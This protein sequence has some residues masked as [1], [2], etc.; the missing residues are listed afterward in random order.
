MKKNDFISAKS[1][2]K[3]IERVM[4]EDTKLIQKRK[5]ERKQN[6]INTYKKKQKQEIEHFKSSYE[7][8]LVNIQ[9]KWSARLEEERKKMNIVDARNEKKNNVI[10][11]EQKINVNVKEPEGSLKAKVNPRSKTNR[12]LKGQNKDSDKIA[13]SFIIQDSNHKESDQLQ[14]D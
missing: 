4:K 1:L 11:T 9:N 5:D 7:T 3:E 2:S 8:I 10:I 6:L 14:D 13:D 12:E